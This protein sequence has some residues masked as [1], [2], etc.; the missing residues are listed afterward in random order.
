[1]GEGDIIKN[2]T[3]LHLYVPAKLAGGK[4]KVDVLVTDLLAEISKRK[5]YTVDVN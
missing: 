3:R 1:M 2:K 4:Y 5:F